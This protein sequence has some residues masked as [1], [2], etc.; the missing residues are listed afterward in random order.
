MVIYVKCYLC[1]RTSKFYVGGRSAQHYFFM[2]LCM[3]CM[4]F[5]NCYYFQ[6]VVQAY[7]IG[8]V[9]TYYDQVVVFKALF[10]TVAVVIGLSLYT[11][12]SKRD[13]SSLGFG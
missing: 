4:L 8:V 1:L 3:Q 11:F 10:L 6:T 7:T 2:K 13:F 9:L 5:D 12:Q